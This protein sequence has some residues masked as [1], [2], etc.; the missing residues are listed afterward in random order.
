MTRSNI[1]PSHVAVLVPSVEKAAKYLE[2]F[3]FQIGSVDDF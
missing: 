2:K 1:V 3:D